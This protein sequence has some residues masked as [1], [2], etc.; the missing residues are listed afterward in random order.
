MAFPPSFPQAIV[1][2]YQ[3]FI[4]SSRKKSVGQRET[5]LLWD[6]GSHYEAL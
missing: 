4:R 1:D 3:L 6:L 2:H 5:L